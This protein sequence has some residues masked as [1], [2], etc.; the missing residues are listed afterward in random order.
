LTGRVAQRLRA[1]LQSAHV[2]SIEKRDEEA[3][4]VARIAD[5]AREVQLASAGLEGHFQD[6]AEGAAPTLMLARLTTAMSEL[7]SARDAFDALLAAK[8]SAE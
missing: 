2:K 8:G 1:K 4:A 6:A 7:Q 5:P 3:A